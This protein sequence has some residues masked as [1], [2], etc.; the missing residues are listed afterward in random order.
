MVVGREQRLFAA[1]EDVL[2]I[3]PYFRDA[4]KEKSGEDDSKQLALPD[5]LVPVLSYYL[6]TAVYSH[7]IG[8]LRYCPA[9]SS[10][11]TK[12]II[13]HACFTAS[14]ETLGTS[15]MLRML[16]TTVAARAKRRSSTLLWKALYSETRWCTAL[17]RST[18]WKN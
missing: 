14:V 10:S 5:E 9:F 12:A 7:V 15:R 13:T 6:S 4:L 11:Y 3:S 2:S 8:S 1:H 16:T 18:A 17:P